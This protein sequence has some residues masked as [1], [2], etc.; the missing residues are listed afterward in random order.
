GSPLGEFARICR[1]SRSCNSFRNRPYGRP[2]LLCPKENK[3]MSEVLAFN[4]LG[5]WLRER[6]DPKS[7]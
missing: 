5:D 4:M 2:I 6:L 3:G 7:D 1:R